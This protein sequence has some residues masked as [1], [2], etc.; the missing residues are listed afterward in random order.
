M[1]YLLLKV[2]FPY[3]PYHRRY[4]YGLNF[5]GRLIALSQKTIDRRVEK[6]LRW[7]GITQH[8]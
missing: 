8:V 6:L 7:I 3:T 1:I 4:I 5:F 2:R